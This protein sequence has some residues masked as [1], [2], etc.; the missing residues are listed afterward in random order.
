M[1]VHVG[2]QQWDRH[3]EPERLL[4]HGLE[5]WELLDFWLGDRDAWSEHCVELVPELLLDLRVVDQLGDGPF[6]RPQGCFNCCTGC[7]TLISTDLSDPTDEWASDN[8][9]DYQTIECRC[10]ELDYKITQ[11]D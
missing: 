10:L 3:P 9:D 8:R 2:D 6:D 7:K 11:L 1:E 5:V 4:D